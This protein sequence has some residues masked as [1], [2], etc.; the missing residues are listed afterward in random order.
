VRLLPKDESFW[1]FFNE[2]TA[3]LNSAA[4]LLAEATKAENSALAGAAARIKAIEQESA[5]TL[6]ELHRKLHKTFVTPIDPE[7]ISLLSEQVDHLLDDLEAICYRLVAYHLDPTP[8]TVAGLA[9]NVHRSAELIQ[10]AFGYLSIGDSVDTLC[11]EIHTMEEEMD[12]ATREAV[13][14]L[15]E[16]EK[17]P[18]ALM[19]NKDI[20]EIFERLGESTQDLA[21]SL[22]N[23]AIKNS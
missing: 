15:F 18:I 8:P 11:H 23:V 1:Q 17:D 19:K 22:E 20:Y 9:A 4:R 13:T 14:Q 16:R 2:Q 3:G 12:Q 5:K 21:D 10:K 7:D 6:H